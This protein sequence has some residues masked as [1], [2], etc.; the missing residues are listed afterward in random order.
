MHSQFQ[1][2]KILLLLLSII[3][4][5]CITAY[6]TSSTTKIYNTNKTRAVKLVEQLTLEEKISILQ[7]NP[8]ES[9]DFGYIGY[10]PGIERLNIPG[11]K[12]ND[13]PEGFRTSTKYQGTSTQFPSGLSMAHTFDKSLIYKYGEA[14]GDEFYRKG[15]TVQFGPGANIARIANGGRSFEYISGE[16]PYLGYQLLQPVIQGIQSKHVIANVKHYINNNQEGVYKYKT[17][18]DHIFGPGDRHSTSAELD[19]RTQMEIYFPP[20]E[21]AVKAQALSFMCA[22]NLVNNIYA[23]ENNRTQNTYLRDWNDFQGWICSDYDA[24]RST[25]DAALGGLD[26]AMPGPPVHADYFGTML[27]SA[28]Q[29]GEVPEEVINEKAVR[30]IYSLIQIGALDIIN[31]NNP[32]NDVTSP[33]H[34]ALARK[35]ASSTCVLLKNEDKTLPIIISPSSNMKIAVIGSAGAIKNGT[36]NGTAIFG[37][38]GSGNVVPKHPI[39]ILDALNTR[40]IDEKNIEITYASGVDIDNAIKVAKEAD[41]VIIVLAESSTEGHDRPENI[42]LPQ[43]DVA[44]SIGKVLMGE[45]NKNQKK[46]KKMIVVTISPGPFVTHSW[47]EYANAFIDMGFPGEQEGN[48]LV[49]ILLG[50]VNPSGKMPHSMPNIANEMKMTYAQYPGLKPDNKTG[51]PCSFNAR[52]EAKFQPCSPTKAIYSEEL[53]IG[54][55]WYEAN[56]V[57]PAFPFGH[58]LSYTTFQY[59]NL[60]VR[61]DNVEH[62]DVI[63]SCDVENTGDVLGAEVVQLYIK[64]PNSAGE[65]FKQLRGFEK[66]TLRNGEKKEVTFTVTTRWLSIWNP[67]IHNWELIHGT[68]SIYVGSSIEDIRLSGEL[69]V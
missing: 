63:I 65:P 16:D 33:E 9:K 67:D 21:G 48:G 50:E 10:V 61:H 45:T 11:I 4:L 44:S 49:D 51:P 43:S 32:S 7:G 54:Y 47:I 53:L 36:N 19:E 17:P 27:L 5:K 64:Y 39:S 37:G 22:N 62:D 34:Y 41:Y 1:R 29:N 42:T 56:N 6:T 25:I 24:T 26:I 46:K 60:N 66:M 59:S 31:K 14:M 20:F 2:M 23:C 57:K 35:L 28:V 8:K 38:G 3:F 52:P 13:G 40:F 69:E 55:R 15:A 58:G 30:I 12:M 68:H 18:H